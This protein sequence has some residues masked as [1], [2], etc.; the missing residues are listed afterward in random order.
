MRIIFAGSS[1]YGIPALEELM[2]Q[3]K[4]EIALVISQ[5]AR[6]KGRKLRLEDTP[7]A[8]AAAMLGLEVY[9]PEDLNS[10]S[11]FAKIAAAEAEIII[12]ASYGA[13]LGR[14]LR[15]LPRYGAINLHPSLLPK[16]RG[17]SPIQA[18][19]LAGDTH[20]GNSIFRLSA[21]MDAGPIYMQKSLAIEDNEN[22]SSLHDRLANQAAQ[23]LISLLEDIHQ[24]KPQPQSELDISYSQMISKADLKLDFSR[25]ASSL[26]R[27]VRAY[28]DEP[29]AYT[30]FRGK[31]LKILEVEILP[32]LHH[33]APGSICQV[34]KNQGILI[35]TGDDELLIRRVQAAGKKQMD[36]WTYSLG[37]RFQPEERIDQ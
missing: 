30:S 20:S 37:A 5:P 14:K 24:I 31:E 1:E 23:L 12:T 8:Q 36:A 15:Q 32:P 26:Q 19:I 4:H 25:S 27:Q 9:N 11:S 18:A 22:F 34:I 28:A 13:F 10:A 6:P 35:A 33:L 2:A 7:L 3:R 16:Y 21:R 29:A 17:A